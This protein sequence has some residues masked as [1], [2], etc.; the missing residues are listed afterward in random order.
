MRIKCLPVATQCFEQN[1]D[2]HS[3][4]I[5]L[6]YGVDTKQNSATDCQLFCQNKEGCDFF[7]FN[8]V[9]KECWLK[10]SDVGRRVAYHHISGT[11]FCVGT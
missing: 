3:N 8:T 6:G 1:T 10:T 4:V 2:F 7:T 5:H 11:K 9:S